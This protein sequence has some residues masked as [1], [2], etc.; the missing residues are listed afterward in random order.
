M[1]NEQQFTHCIKCGAVKNE[2][3]ECVKCGVIYAKAERVFREREQEK[4]KQRLYEEEEKKAKAN[5][6]PPL[7]AFD[8]ED[9]QGNKTSRQVKNPVRFTYA[10]N[11]YINGFCLTRQAARTFRIDRIRG[12]IA[13]A[14]TGE[15]ITPDRILEVDPPDN[16]TGTE[17]EN[18]TQGLIGCPTCGKPISENA[19]SCPHCGEP[20]KKENPLHPPPKPPLPKKPLGCLGWAFILF[21]VLYLIGQCDHKPEPV[22][23]KIRE[24]R[25]QP[26]PPP[27]PT[28]QPH[29]D[30]SPNEQRS[31]TPRAIDFASAFVAAMNS[32]YGNVCHAELNGLFSKTLKIDWTS[33][34]K[35]IHA[36]K[37]LAEVGDS[38]DKLYEDG[39]RYFQFPN[40]AGTYN[41]IDWKTG[42]K[43]SISEGAMYY[44]PD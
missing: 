18:S 31:Y 7:I 24:Q 44:F 39:V 43:K 17:G 6:R 5:R 38:K 32:L 4:E 25:E 26:T 13:D 10:Q 12:D 34:T 1:P 29:S 14:E 22:P 21:F 41:V 40:D 36:I 3:V 2:G 42:E 33:N 19:E 37:V 28:P 35:K 27:T 16:L 8:Y 15:I 9:A 23:P 30:S 11:D 20:L